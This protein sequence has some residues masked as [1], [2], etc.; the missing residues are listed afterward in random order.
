MKHLIYSIDIALI[1]SLN[2]MVEVHFNEHILNYSNIEDYAQ[3]ILGENLG[4]HFIHY[5]WPENTEIITK[6]NGLQIPKNSLYITNSAYMC[7]LILHI[8]VLMYH[9]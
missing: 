6:K 2:A 9:L 4:K 7:L 1:F 8:I 5:Q 3:M